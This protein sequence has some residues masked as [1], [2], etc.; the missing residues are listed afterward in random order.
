MKRHEVEEYEIEY[1]CKEF[2]ELDR[3]DIIDLLEALE[4]DKWG[5]SSAETTTQESH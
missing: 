2:P 3:Q 1:W 4:D 5:I